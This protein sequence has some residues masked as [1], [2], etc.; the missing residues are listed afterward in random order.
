MLG[1]IPPTMLWTT[2]G[3]PTIQ[4]NS[5]A[6]YLEMASDP[7]GKGSVTQD[8]TPTPTHFRHQSEVH[9][10]TCAFEVPTTSCSGS[11]NLLEWLTEHR[12][13]SYLQNHQFIKQGHNSGAARWKRYVRPGTGKGWGASMSSPAPPLSHFPMSP[14]GK[15][16]TP[17]PLWFSWRLHYIGVFH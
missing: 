16:F 4:L 5:N 9:V 15:L 14:A 12:E 2:A 1:D 3:C 10:I 17:T 11:I 13:A 8:C 7:S 6:V